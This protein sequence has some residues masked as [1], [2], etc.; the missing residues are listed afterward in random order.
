MET[1]HVLN[2]PHAHRRPDQLYAF[3]ATGIAKRFRHTASFGA[4]DAVEAGE[5]MKLFNDH[6]PLVLLAQIQQRYGERVCIAYQSRSPE[7]V[8]ISF[9]IVKS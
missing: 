6:D 7:G 3:R 5:T 8:L 4:L 9:S 2:Q 1:I